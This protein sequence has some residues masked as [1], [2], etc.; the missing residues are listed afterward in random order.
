MADPAQTQEPV[1]EFA[2]THA[3][4]FEG[5]NLQ[6]VVVVQMY[7]H[8]RDDLVR[9]IVPDLVQTAGEVAASGNLLA[10]GGEK[11]FWRGDGKAGELP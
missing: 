7:V 2:D 5:D 6:A 11:I 1:G 8:G 3:D 9:V 10:K 4:S